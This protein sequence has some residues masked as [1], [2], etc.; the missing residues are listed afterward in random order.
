MWTTTGKARRR[1]AAR[2]FTLM[3]LMV[4][5]AAGLILS[6]AAFSFSRQATRAFAQESRIASAQMS[7][8]AHAADTDESDANLRHHAI[9]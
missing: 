5:M 6:I 1:T 8:L 9:L 4:A 3:E 7:V 2:G